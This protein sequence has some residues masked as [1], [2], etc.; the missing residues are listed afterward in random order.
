MKTAKHFSDYWKP[1]ARIAPTV[2]CFEPKINSNSNSNL[3][4]LVWIFWQLGPGP[5]STEALVGDP[6]ITT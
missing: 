6:S 1:I 5:V 4:Q 2:K 3:Q